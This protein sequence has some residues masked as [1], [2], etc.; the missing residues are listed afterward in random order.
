MPKKLPLNT[1][2]KLHRFR[3]LQRL[4]AAENETEKRKF[5]RRLQHG[6]RTPDVKDDDG[7]VIVPG[8]VTLMRS[9]MVDRM[10][11]GCRGVDR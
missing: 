4:L 8:Q 1:K 2:K 6:Q 10:L 11:E 3:G 9:R 5:E 7:N